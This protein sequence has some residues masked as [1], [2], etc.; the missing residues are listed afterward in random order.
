MAEACWHC[1]SFPSRHSL[2]A[3]RRT[4]SSAFPRSNLPGTRSSSTIRT[5]ATIPANENA[6]EL[7]RQAGR[8]VTPA[9][10][11]LYKAI[12]KDWGDMPAEDQDLVPEQYQG[13]GI[14]S[15]GRRETVL[16]VCGPR[17]ADRFSTRLTRELPPLGSFS[18]RS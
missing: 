10:D 11:D 9:P 17:Q 1:S 16:S 13:A 7:Y 18:T 5:S 6:A 8:A 15:P 12:A 4:A 3:M 14:D 2:P